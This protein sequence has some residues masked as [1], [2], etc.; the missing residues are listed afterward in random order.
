VAV[1]MAAAE[2]YSVRAKPTN[3]W[4]VVSPKHERG[5]P[6]KGV[7]SANVIRLTSE[8]GTPIFARRCNT[9]TSI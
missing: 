4:G 3:I 6:A 2:A 5:T 1:A 8:A 9:A 7:A